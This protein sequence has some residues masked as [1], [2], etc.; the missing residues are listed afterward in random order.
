MG[1]KVL[2]LGSG[3][4]E[5]ALAWKV[6][7]S[8]CVSEVI[9]APGNGGISEEATCVS[10]DLKNIDSI[11]ELANRLQP[12]L[13]VVGPE[14]PLTLGVVDEFNRRALRVFGP[15]QAAARLAPSKSFTKEFLRRFNIPTA[16]YAIC[17]TA[18]EDTALP[19]HF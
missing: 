12:D 5:H 19:S 10:A 9:C 8:P 17:N 6:R 18:E 3:G 4:R 2:I 16:G 11:V 14:L 13:T 15:T 1:M 7:Q